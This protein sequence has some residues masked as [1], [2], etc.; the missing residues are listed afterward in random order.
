M[1]VKVEDQISAL[2]KKAQYMAK[3]V[4][5]DENNLN[6]VVKQIYAKQGV[7]PPK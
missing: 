5:E 1:M 6:E 2:D 7:T 4:K 3:Q